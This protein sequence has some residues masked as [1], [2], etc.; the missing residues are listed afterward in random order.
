MNAKIQIISTMKKII[1]FLFALLVTIPSEGLRAE[2]CDS[3]SIADIERYAVQTPPVV[4]K[5]EFPGGKSAMSEYVRH[6]L[7]YPVKARE[8]LIQGKVKIQFTVEA[9]GTVTNPEVIEGFCPECDAEALRLVAS[10]PRFS[11]GTRN[12]VPV[13]V[14]CFLPIQ[15]KLFV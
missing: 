8:K 15:F 2:D 9:D 3:A 5:P 1:F 14:V 4:V 11:P 7:N 13:P 10:L 6:H 12:G